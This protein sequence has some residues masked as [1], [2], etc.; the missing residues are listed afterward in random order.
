[1]A[2][3]TLY[4]D[5][6]ILPRE[7]RNDLMGKVQNQSVIAT[8]VP[9]EPESFVSVEHINF[10]D[11]GGGEWVG[12][13]ANKSSMPAEWDYVKPSIHKAQ[14]TR[15]FSDE[16]RWA[17]EDARTEILARLLDDMARKMADMVDAGII[18]AAE[19]NSRSIVTDMKSEAIAWTANQVAATTDIV[20]D[21]DSINDTFVEDY[22]MTGI[23]FDRVYANDMRKVRNPTTGI[24]MYPEIPMG[25]QITN[26]NGLNA[27]MSG[28]VA[29]KRFLPVGSPSGIK[30]I[31]GN[32]NMLKWGYV[33]EFGLQEIQYGD[34]DGNGDLQRKNEVAY[35]LE[36][37]LAWMIADPKAFA[38]LRDSSTIPSDDGG[39]NDGGD[40]DDSGTET[41]TAKAKAASK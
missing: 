38:V 32:W 25:L 28:N 9:T 29:G 34:P 15:R 11:A 40:N 24:Q 14:I 3:N 6:L 8:L 12:E 27:V 2:T 4:T 22:D 10:K 19:P 20:K 39:D 1:M 18:H 23:A 31:A 26:F 17:D 21:I 35:R 37:V 30:A 5:K 33:R 7:I 36:A 13:G 41:Q 16:F